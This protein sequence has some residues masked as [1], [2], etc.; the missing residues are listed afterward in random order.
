MR[1]TKLTAHYYT[2]VEQYSLGRLHKLQCLQAVEH[3]SDNLLTLSIEQTDG[4]DI[5]LYS[6]DGLSDDNNASPTP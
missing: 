5:E 2:C 1:F 6:Y 3:C 4:S